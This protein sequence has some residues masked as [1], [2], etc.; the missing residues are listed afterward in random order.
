MTS[1]L[2][3]PPR[4]TETWPRDDLWRRT[5][6]RGILGALVLGGIALDL[7]TRFPA[8]LMSF[9][10]ICV[11]ASAGLVG[12]WARDR[13][14]AVLLAASLFPAALL[15]V[16]DSA[17]L[18]PLNVTAAT[19]LLL[20]AAA[21]RPEPGSLGRAVGRM[22]RP[23]AALEPAARSADLV[24]RA[25]RSEFSA[26]DALWPR[27]RRVLTGAAIGAP[28]AVV[29][30][31]LLAASD[32]LF[33]SW[34]TAPVDVGFVIGH[35]L[36]VLIGAT[37]MAGVAGHG[38]WARPPL[39]TTPRA[40]LGP[41]EATVVLGAVVVVYLGFVVAQVVAIAGGAAYVER[42]TGLSYP[43][44]ARAGF[45]QLV[46]AAVITLVVLVLVARHRRHAAPRAARRLLVLSEAIVVLTLVVVA[47]A[48]RRL[49]L[50]EAAFGLTML[51]LYTIVFAAFIGFVFV[52][53]G[54][55]LADRLG[56]SPLAVV[57]TGAFG[58]LL[59]MNLVNPERIVAE[60]N[61]GRFGGTP[62]LDTA[63]LADSLGA[64]A[65]PTLLEDPATAAVVCARS[66]TLDD[67][68]ITFN[69]GRHRAADAIVEV[70]G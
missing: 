60:R 49:F 34:V 65:L 21:S 40:L 35:L 23:M 33:R 19:A 43:D 39:P 46:A 28:V 29:L 41:T 52:V 54:L 18:V 38:A 5:P 16:R 69:V 51:R 24:T 66:P 11:A 6:G 13:P 22:L 62:A 10:A 36:I 42:T 12:G 17:W 32:A 1:T 57:V 37:L 50:Y 55:F 61:I 27:L 45:F 68:A 25:V 20:L 56:H 64:D 26:H 63:Y 59:M 2:P 7:G 67:R 44:Y 30:I 53:V 31:A 70:C 15:I 58:F 4:S 47:V 8:G 14:A 9:T 48:I 3:P